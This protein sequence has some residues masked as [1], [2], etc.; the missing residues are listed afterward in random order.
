MKT[1]IF[2]VV[3]V[4]IAAIVIAALKKKHTADRHGGQQLVQLRAVLHRRAFLLNNLIDSR[5]T[6]GC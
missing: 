3:L 5:T 1:L 6:E 4:V 2:L